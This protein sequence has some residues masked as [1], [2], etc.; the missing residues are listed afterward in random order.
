MKRSFTYILIIT[1]LGQSCIVYQDV[2]VSINDA[3]NE[4]KVKA[5]NSFG[6]EFILRKIHYS[7]STYS[8]KYKFDRIQLDTNQ[9]ESIYL[10]DIGKSKKKTTKTV[11]ISGVIIISIPVL[12]IGGTIICF[13]WG[14]CGW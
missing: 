11:L 7:D 1:L 4:R 13:T 12:I 5:I 10:K 2:P 6:N 9:I 14:D 8:A 3:V